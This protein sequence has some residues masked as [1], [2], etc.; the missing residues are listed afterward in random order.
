MRTPQ[1]SGLEALWARAGQAGHLR[2]EVESARVA[3]QERSLAEAREHLE[4][5]DYL[6]SESHCLQSLSQRPVFF[7]FHL[8][9]PSHALTIPYPAVW[10]ASV[11]E[12]Q[13]DCVLGMTLRI[14]Y[15]DRKAD[16]WKE[17]A[18]KRA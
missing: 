14:F 4:Q 11:A 18:S 15:S 9:H 7:T 3:E 16:Y 17:D 5:W 12:Q 6:V 13:L 2:L 8:R 1:K 10:T